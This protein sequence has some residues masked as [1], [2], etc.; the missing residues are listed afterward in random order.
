MPGRGVYETVKQAIQEVVAPQLQELKGDIAGLRGEIVG[1]WGEMR[2]IEK[3]MED[4]FTSLRSEM[5]VRFAALDE[6][7]IQR[8]DHT[9]KRLE[10]ALEICERLAVLEARIA[11][12]S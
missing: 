4:G 8:L 7:F 6:K 5:N 10:E 11:S 12:H 1:L 2:Q 9:N 3:R